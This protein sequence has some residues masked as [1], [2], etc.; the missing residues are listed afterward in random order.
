MHLDLEGL[1]QFHFKNSANNSVF[2][3][4]IPQLLLSQYGDTGGEKYRP[5]PM[6]CFF[7]VL[8]PWH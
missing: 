8:A 5:D 4:I 7:L 1:S 2:K 3:S 6:S